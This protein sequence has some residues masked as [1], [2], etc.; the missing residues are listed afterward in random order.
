MTEKVGR[1]CRRR[2]KK[3]AIDFQINGGN[4]AST[5]EAFIPIQTG[6]N[7]FFTGSKFTYAYR[8]IKV[9]RHGKRRRTKLHTAHN[10]EVEFSTSCVLPS[11]AKPQDS[12]S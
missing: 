2:S 6:G 3:V 1:L 5:S 8:I 4:A 10:Y 12:E 9:A 11:I 7:T